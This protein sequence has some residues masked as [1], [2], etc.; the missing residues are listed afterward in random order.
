MILVF[1]YINI[2]LILV[3][4]WT[5]QMGQT[6]DA[7]AFNPFPAQDSLFCSFDLIILFIENIVI[8]N[9]D[10]QHFK[11]L[12]VMQLLSHEFRRGYV[13]VLQRNLLK[14]LNDN[15]GWTYSHCFSFYFNY[16]SSSMRSTCKFQNLLYISI[17]DEAWITSPCDIVRMDLRVGI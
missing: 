15:Y 7:L 4:R 12:C 16:T 1:F 10:V 3:K 2:V 8:L 5:H 11:K 13:F 9:S 17:I 14:L 6:W